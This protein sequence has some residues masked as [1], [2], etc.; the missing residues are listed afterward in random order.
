ME[1]Q[2]TNL[3]LFT[4]QVA[5]ATYAL[6]E[7]KEASDKQDIFDSLT[8]LITTR[9]AAINALKEQL[10]ENVCSLPSKGVS[11][12]TIATIGEG[13]L[14]GARVICS[15]MA[16]FAREL[17]SI[18]HDADILYYYESV[19]ERTE[20]AFSEILQPYRE[21]AGRVIADQEFA[22]Y[23]EIYHTFSN[24]KKQNND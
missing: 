21:A 3:K 11:S 4:A 9:E 22:A 8:S 1:I 13:Y 23:S 7:L 20:N 24:F 14:Y 16:I 12:A 2:P 15:Q 6:D 18:G 19:S 10:I 17:A 5:A